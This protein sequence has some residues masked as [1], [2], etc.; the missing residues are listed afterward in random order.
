MLAGGS[1]VD[2]RFRDKFEVR[3]LVW[4]LSALP[5]RLV[6]ENDAK[7]WGDCVCCQ[8]DV[9]G[10]EGPK[11][12]LCLDYMVDAHASIILDPLSHVFTHHPAQHKLVNFTAILH[13]Y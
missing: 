1:P 5:E 11:S 12:R 3:W 10:V 2:V 13:V 4:W 8:S 9:I 7:T 6:S